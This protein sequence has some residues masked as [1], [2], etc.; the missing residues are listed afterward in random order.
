MFMGLINC[1]GLAIYPPRLSNLL[2]SVSDDA[3]TLASKFRQSTL[4]PCVC[5]CVALFYFRMHV[6][7]FP[8]NV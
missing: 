1:Y 4:Q 2:P 3:P 5:A 7:I 8:I 6:K